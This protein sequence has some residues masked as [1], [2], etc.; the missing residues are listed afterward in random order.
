MVES[1]NSL[2]KGLN[3]LNRSLKLLV[4]P[5]SHSKKIN[6]KRENPYSSG[7]LSKRSHLIVPHNQIPHVASQAICQTY[8]L[9]I[10]PSQ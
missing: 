2:D 4:Y 8:K 9:N 6:I 10:I 5:I 7:Q 3:I 1:L